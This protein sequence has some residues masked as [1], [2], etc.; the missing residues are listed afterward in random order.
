MIEMALAMPAPIENTAATN[1]N[2]TK[3]I[4]ILNTLVVVARGDLPK[5]IMQRIRVSRYI[6]H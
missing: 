2:E 1:S 5:F 3:N 6:R 4:S